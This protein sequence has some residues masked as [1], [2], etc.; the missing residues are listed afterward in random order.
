[1]LLILDYLVGSLAIL[2]TI[3]AYYQKDMTRFLQINIL[4]ASFFSATLYINGAI[5][6]ALIV[7]LSVAVYVIALMISPSTKKTLT[8]IIPP[9]AFMISYYGY[10]N[11]VIS[12]YPLGDFIP[13]IPAFASLLIT[14]SALQHN[15][16][17]NKILLSLGLVLWI[18]Y[19]FI[20]QAWFA[21]TADAL[22]LVSVLASLYV[23]K[24]R[25]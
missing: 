16:V 14:L 18:I 23:I 10:D 20:Y 22:G 5:T 2:F 4:A 24:K 25:G 15:I 7:L 3:I 17:S 6:G 11:P 19:T 1:M 8:K 21:F 9:L 13:Y 12:H